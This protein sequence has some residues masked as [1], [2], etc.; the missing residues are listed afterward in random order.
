MI[1]TQEGKPRGY[2]FVEYKHER[3]MMSK[4]NTLLLSA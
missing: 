4:N 1:T 3:D 2:A